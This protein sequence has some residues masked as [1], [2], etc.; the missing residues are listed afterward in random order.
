MMNVDR[1][2]VT[3]N[4]LFVISVSVLYQ[5]CLDGTFVLATGITVLIEASG[6]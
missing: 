6:T 5:F 4:S 3:S 2:K 1:F